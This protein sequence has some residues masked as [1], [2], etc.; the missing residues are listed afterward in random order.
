MRDEGNMDEF[1]HGYFDAVMAAV[2]ERI[3]READAAG[4]PVDA[5]EQKL[6]DE[7]RERTELER[8][9]SE[10]ER[11][12]TQ[13][14]R[15][16][17][18][19][20]DSGYRALVNGERLRATD[21]LRVVKRWCDKLPE[22]HRFL[23]LTGGTGCGKTFAAA[24]AMAIAKSRVEYVRA[25]HLADRHDPYGWD[26]DRGV[27]PLRMSAPL[28]VVDDVGTERRNADG[29]RDQRF[30]PALSDIIDS[31]QQLRTIITTNL[32]KAAFLETYCDPR[33]ASRLA[34]SGHFHGC[35]NTDLRRGQA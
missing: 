24:Y 21:A 27:V 11:R 9:A 7:E 3:Q 17:A 2:Q 33:M 23:V 10:R 18:H 4:M 28:M 35:G 32:S 30:M 12:E 1:A 13:L 31:R 8:K 5:Y 6:R 14:E 19:L 29:R 15:V 25:S 22:K 34:Q 16:R 26:R 20:T